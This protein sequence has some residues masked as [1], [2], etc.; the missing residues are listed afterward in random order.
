M[1][2]QKEC[3]SCHILKETSSFNFDQT[4]K[5]KLMCWCKE[6]LRQSHII[7]YQRNRCDILAEN[8]VYRDTHLEIRKILEKSYYETHKEAQQQ[9]GKKWQAQHPEQWKILYTKHH[10]LYRIRHPE[11]I[12]ELNTKRKR[13]L[14]WNI[15]YPN[16]IN[17]DV[18]WHHVTDNDVAALP[19]DLHNLYGGRDKEAHRI[20]LSYIV[21]QI[22]GGV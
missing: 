14:G 15:L 18:A 16:I 20:N 8:K 3:T 22:Y 4:R 21:S 2:Q 9:R 1:S 10:K 12:K 13:E 5:D 17:E 11:K 6:C 7:R 19:E